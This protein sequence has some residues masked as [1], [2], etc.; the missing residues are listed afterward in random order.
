M[1]ASWPGPVF[2]FVVVVVVVLLLLLLLL[3][4]L[5]VEAVIAE[6]YLK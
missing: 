5:V 3:L 2:S 6:L 1:A 4:V